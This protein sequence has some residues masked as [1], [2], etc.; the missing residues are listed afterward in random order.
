MPRGIQF[1]ARCR[2]R[3]VGE[4]PSR[5]AGLP[6]DAC[7]TRLGVPL[8]ARGSAG[9]S[10]RHKGYILLHGCSVTLLRQGL[11]LWGQGCLGAASLCITPRRLG[12]RW[13]LSSRA[14][15]SPS[16]P[17]TQDVSTGTGRRQERPVP[18][19]CHPARREGAAA[20]ELG[21]AP[22]PLPPL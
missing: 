20:A 4:A 6:G 9:P 18:A 22:T 3:G 13:R 14:R 10:L 17:K 11:P 8:L 15:A 19:P 16:I 7:C 21:G 12:P 1:E 2:A 5:Q